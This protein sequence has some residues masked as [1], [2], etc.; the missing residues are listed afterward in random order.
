[1]KSDR[2]HVTTPDPHYPERIKI[3]FFSEPVQLHSVTPSSETNQS[4][5]NE[6]GGYSV[7]IDGIGHQKYKYYFD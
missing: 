5:S 1:M 6:S 7:L 2:N 4:P 3:N